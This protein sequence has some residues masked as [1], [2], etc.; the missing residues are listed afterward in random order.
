L[1]SIP[2]T[3][4]KTVQAVELWSKNRYLFVPILVDVGA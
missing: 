3:R 2:P 1:Q 4:A